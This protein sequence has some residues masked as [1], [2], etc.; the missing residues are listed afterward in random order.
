ME[1]FRF[2]EQPTEV[3]EEVSLEFSVSRIE[4]RVNNESRQNDRESSAGFQEKRRKWKEKF[5][6]TAMVTVMFMAGHL[7]GIEGTS[8]GQIAREWEGSVKAEEIE[9]NVD[10]QAAKFKLEQWFREIFV[11]VPKKTG[12]NLNI[13]LDLG[14]KADVEKMSLKIVEVFSPEGIGH[15]NENGSDVFYFDSFA[16]KDKIHEKDLDKLRNLLNA[17]EGRKDF[18]LKMKTEQTSFT[19]EDSW[20]ILNQYFDTKTIHKILSENLDSVTYSDEEVGYYAYGME[21]KARAYVDKLKTGKSV[22]KVEK[23]FIEFGGARVGLDVFLHELGH[24]IDPERSEN[25][26]VSS[27]ASV[28]W[29]EA[30]KMSGKESF[31]YPKNIKT[32]ILYRY[33]EEE[34]KRREDFAESFREL[35]LNPE[36]FSAQDPVRFHYMREFLM[37]SKEKTRDVTKPEY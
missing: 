25:N 33:F 3:P 19:A 15:A 13:K 11:E 8:K 23:N 37:W 27:S 28:D 9:K 32:P 21:G 12:E 18:S 26:K 17:F 31:Q 22:I 5:S 14:P 1:S 2:P 20:H 7:A 10:S 16:G 24:V 36:S 35:L 34:F 29:G 6:N 30:R 4:K